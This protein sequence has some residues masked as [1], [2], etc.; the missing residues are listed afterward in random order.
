VKFAPTDPR[1]EPLEAIRSSRSDGR[2]CSSATGMYRALVRRN[3]RPYTRC[4]R[5]LHGQN[6]AI[7]TGIAKANQLRE[8]VQDSSATGPKG[9][10]GCCWTIRSKRNER[11]AH[12]TPLDPLAHCARSGDS[13]AA[14]SCP[15]LAWADNSIDC[16][17][18][19]AGSTDAP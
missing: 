7:I 1:K 5:Q 6:F 8:L 13:P 9:R 16:G 4:V 10:A 12:T 18:S 19:L 2:H 14:C 11:N 3:D 15:T 17:R